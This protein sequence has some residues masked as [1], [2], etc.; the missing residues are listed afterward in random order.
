MA[1]SLH[2]P[3]LP[4][5]REAGRRHPRPLFAARPANCWPFCFEACAG[6]RIRRLC[7]PAVAV[8]RA[9]C[10]LA[11]SPF[12]CHAHCPHHLAP[13][14]FACPRPF[15]FCFIVL[16]HLFHVH[17]RQDRRLGPA[18]CRRKFVVQQFASYELSR[19]QLQHGPAVA[20]R[21]PGPFDC[22]FFFLQSP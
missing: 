15:H 8:Q 7:S 14:K 6:R 12:A 21:A 18:V 4:A 5:R 16:C 22:F 9:V 2:S 19:W 11:C 3:H 1:A 17:V 13:I 10:L 20:A